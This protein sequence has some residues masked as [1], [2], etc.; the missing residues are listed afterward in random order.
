MTANVEHIFFSE[1]T[2]REELTLKLE[3][4]AQNSATITITSTVRLFSDIASVLLRL[5]NRVLS[6]SVTRSIL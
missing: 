2:T 5:P 6:R 1:S 3:Q 4:E